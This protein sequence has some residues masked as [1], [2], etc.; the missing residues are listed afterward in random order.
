MASG[1]IIGFDEQSFRQLRQELAELRRE[2]VNFRRTLA[3]LTTGRHDAPTPQ[4]PRRIRFKNNNSGVAPAYG[5]LRVTGASTA[6]YLT[7]DQPDSTYRWLYLVNG[8]SK[9][10]AGGYGYGSY[11]TAENF[12]FHSNYVLYDTGSGTPAYGDEWGPTASSWKLQKYA[13]GFWIMGAN[14]TDV[15]GSERTVAVQVPP[16]EVLVK[17]ATGSAIGAAASGT[18][19][20]EGGSAGSESTLGMTLTAWNHSSVSFADTKFGAVGRMCGNNYAVPFQ[21]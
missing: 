20:L 17:N 13:P 6:G 11:L 21:T 1:D 3:L 16:N 12:N 14:N 7:I 5:V 18:F 2:S 19:T 8:R 15:S 9:V 4:A 10:P